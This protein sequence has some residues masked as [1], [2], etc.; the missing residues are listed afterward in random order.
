MFV[1]KHLQVLFFRLSLILISCQLFQAAS[2]QI[3]FACFYRERC[4]GGG[5]EGIVTG[6]EGLRERGVVSRQKGPQ[7]L[8]TSI[9]RRMVLEL[10]TQMTCI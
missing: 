9:R 4:V 2:A 10:A 5:G 8:G 7:P 3:F 1:Q 6:Q